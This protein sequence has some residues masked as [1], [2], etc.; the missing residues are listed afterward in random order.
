[1]SLLPSRRN[2]WETRGLRLTSVSG[3]VMEHI[4]DKNIIGSSQHEFIN[5]K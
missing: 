3:K 5:G 1:M 2:I 4:K